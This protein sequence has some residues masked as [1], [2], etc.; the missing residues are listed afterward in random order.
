[1]AT[2]K[3][4][5]VF[6]V[7]GVT[8]EMVATAATLAVARERFKYGLWEIMNKE[9]KKVMYQA[10]FDDGLLELHYDADNGVGYE[11]ITEEV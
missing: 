5:C 11:I 7:H 8:Y 2:K 10:C 4:S 1:M 3:V 9:H 6:E